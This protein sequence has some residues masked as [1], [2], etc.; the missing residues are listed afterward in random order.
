MIQTTLS[1]LAIMVDATL[2]PSNTI[3][4]GISIDTRTLVHGNLY[5]AIAGEQ[6]DGHSFVSEAYQKGASAALLTSSIESPIP[7]VIVKDTVAA[8]GKISERWRNQFSL[9]LIGVTGSNGKTTLKNMIAAILQAACK[10]D[11]AQVLATEGNFNNNIGL[12]LTLSRLSTQHRYG[13]IEMGM[14]HFGEIAYLTQLTKPQVAVINNAAAA[15]LEGVQD[16][17]GVARAKGEIFLGLQK[18]GV[19]ILNKDD[20]FFDYWRGLVT[21]HRY[22]SF[23]LENSADISATLTTMPP[24]STQQLITLHTPQGKISVNLP[25]LGRHNVMNAL[26]ATAATLALDIGLE[27]IKA[28]LENV[29]PAPGRLNQHKLANGACVIDDSYNAN[30]L[31][32][33]AAIQTLASFNGNKILVLGDMRELGPQAKEFHYSAGKNALAAGINMLFT[34]GELSAAATEAFGNNAYHFSDREKLLAALQ[35]HIQDNSITLIKGSN[36]MKMGKI[37]AGLLPA[38]LLIPAH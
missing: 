16:V 25:L 4:Q 15:H 8:L 21:N 24:N 36:S 14:N 17:A 37:V 23:G 22:L 13:V 6:F 20:A 34:V 31:S 27:A 35:P 2:P 1:E 33:Q 5:V 32:L 26:A 3:L 7:Q 11:A 30:P 29:H 12:P 9:P 19:A 28:G 38:N 18:T 10:N